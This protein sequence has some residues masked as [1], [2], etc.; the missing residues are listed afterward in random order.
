MLNH[1][2]TPRD[3]PTPQDRP[4]AYD[5]TYDPG[6]LCA[7]VVDLSRLN[8]EH[9]MFD[10]N[11]GSESGSDNRYVLMLQ[12]MQHAMLAPPMRGMGMMEVKVESVEAA[13]AGTVA[14]VGRRMPKGEVFQSITAILGLEC[15]TLQSLQGLF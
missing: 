15:T 7:A 14:H 6:K 12:R 1:Y 5:P 4:I 2:Y 9:F 13:R 8:F 11:L 10:C 3:A